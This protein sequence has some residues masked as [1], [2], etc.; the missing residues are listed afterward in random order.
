[1]VKLY[2]GT[3]L[4][5]EQIQALDGIVVGEEGGCAASNSCGRS[6]ANL[7][8]EY[9]VY[10]PGKGVYTKW[11]DSEVNWTDESDDPRWSSARFVDG[12][13]YEEGER[14]VYFDETNIYVYEAINNI[15]TS[16]GEFDLSDWNLICRVNAPD[17]ILPLL[18]SL[19]PYHAP[20][21][22]PVSS[23]VL[24]DTKC[25]DSTC[26]YL[27]LGT[28]STTPPNSLD[29]KMLLCV[30]SGKL[31]RCSKELACDNGIPLPLSNSPSRDLICFPSR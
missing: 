13:G 5:P 4:T 30:K 11:G 14:V 27:S 29:W 31:V 26:A 16:P 25:G 18:L 23:T 3:C 6:V 1:M 8:T 17:S 10:N 24:V 19:Y 21:T 15:P 20:G 28:T 22:Y 12:V 7:L 2:S 9:E